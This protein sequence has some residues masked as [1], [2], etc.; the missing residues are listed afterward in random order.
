MIRAEERRWCR[1]LA[2]MSGREMAR[3][4]VAPSDASKAFDFSLYI[5]ALGELSTVKHHDLICLSEL[6]GQ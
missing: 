5:V 6:F 2:E 4:S 1:R 3:L